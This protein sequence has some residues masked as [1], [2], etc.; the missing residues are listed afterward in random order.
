MILYYF[1][2]TTTCEFHET[3]E[4]HESFISSHQEIQLHNNLHTRGSKNLLTFL[5]LI[6]QM[7]FKVIFRFKVSESVR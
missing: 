1:W 6:Y 5:Y 2:V 3:S 4:F 7:I